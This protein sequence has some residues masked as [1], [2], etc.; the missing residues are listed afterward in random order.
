M[1]LIVLVL[2][3]NFVF[4]TS[5]YAQNANSFTYNIDDIETPL[6][7]INKSDIVTAGIVNYFEQLEVVRGFS[8]PIGYIVKFISISEDS[9]VYSMSYFNKKSELKKFGTFYNCSY[10]IDKPLLFTCSDSI[11]NQYSNLMD[12]LGQDKYSEEFLSKI[13]FETGRITD[14]YLE[15]VCIYTNGKVTLNLYM[16]NETPFRYMP[17]SDSSIIMLK[18]Y[19]EYYNKQKK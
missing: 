13:N 3:I 1:K 9:I 6:S 8:Y 7:Y 18:K 5:I 12:T 19:I 16:D 15:G 17:Q 14:A 11:T 4:L 2:S 10:I